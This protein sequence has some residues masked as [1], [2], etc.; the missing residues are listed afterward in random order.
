MPHNP[1]PKYTTPQSVFVGIDVGAYALD[2]CVLPENGDKPLVFQVSNA[3]EGHRRIGR[4]L[5]GLSVI[6]I[7][8]EATG[9]LERPVVRLLSQQGFTVAILNP[10]HVIGF[11]K[12]CGKT[13]KTDALDA[14]LLARFAQTMRPEARPLPAEEILDLRELV[15]RRQQVIT[16]RTAESNRRLRTES[17][18]AKRHIAA[19]LRL[20]DK[21][22]AE[23]DFAL[24]ANVKSHPTLLSRYDLLVSIKGLGPIAAMTLLAEMPE[25][26]SIP[27]K[28]ITA[29]AGLAP[30]NNESGLRK[31]RAKCRGGRK[32]VRCALYM[33]AMAAK[34]FNKP[35]AFFYNRLVAKGKPKLVALNAS[36]RKLLIVANHI[37]ASGKPWVSPPSFSA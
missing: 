17:A 6:R 27:D 14:V 11:R 26:G 5:R 33:A 9:K 8:C 10:I 37:L 18:L 34:R 13:A 29:L 31:R 3:P 32:S 19:T 4:A 36:M 35:I 23:L 24:A 2:V 28:A 7:A 30:M 15:M 16:L 20:L 25:L 1:M 22:L 12:A 21:Q